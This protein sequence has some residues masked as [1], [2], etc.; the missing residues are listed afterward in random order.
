MR[1]KFLPPP[2]YPDMTRVHRNSFRACIE[3]A[4]KGEVFSQNNPIWRTLREWGLVAKGPP[5]LS[6]NRT[7]VPTDE[8][9][10]VWDAYL[11]FTT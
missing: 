9:R 3:A 8:G 6:R 7:W 10:R 2:G 11:R 5:T 1:S 4:D